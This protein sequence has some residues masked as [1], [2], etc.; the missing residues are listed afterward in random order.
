MQNNHTAVAILIG[1]I[2]V[3]GAIF[4]SG[5][6][7][8]SG[9]ADRVAGHGNGTQGS[10]TPD[11]SPRRSGEHTF[12]YGDSDAAITIVEFSDFE[13]PFCARLHPTLTRIVDESDG[14]INWEYRHLPLPS[15]AN[16]EIAAAVGECVGRELGNDAFWKYGETVFDNQRQVDR[17][18][19][20]SLATDLGMERAS[21]ESCMSTDTVQDQIATDLA[22]ARAFGGNGTPFS[23]VQ[24]P[25]GSTQPVSGA[26]PYENWV[27]LLEL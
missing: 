27:P 17:E 19:L 6:P 22:T 18:Y 21:I 11:Q 5:S 10:A 8:G 1:F 9:N 13:C 24:F 16:A 2:L 14:R 3:A 23:V 7:A 15:H 25:D 12:V 4:V 20:V 26:L